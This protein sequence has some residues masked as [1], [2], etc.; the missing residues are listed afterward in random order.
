[1]D[2]KWGDIGKKNS[3]GKVLGVAAGRVSKT[4]LA[5]P[6][7]NSG[8]PSQAGIICYVKSDSPLL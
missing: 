4:A 1:V 2:G 6:L 5:P 7:L 3:S 8:R